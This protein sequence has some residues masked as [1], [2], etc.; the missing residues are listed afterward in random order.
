M[1]PERSMNQLNSYQS[2][3]KPVL[4]CWGA[5]NEMLVYNQNN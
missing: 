4:F 1:I 2:A 5:E 3:K